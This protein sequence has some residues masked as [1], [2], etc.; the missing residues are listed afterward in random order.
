MRVLLLVTVIAFLAIP[1]GDAEACSCVARTAAEHAKAAKRVMLARAGKPTKTG[2]HLKQSFTVLATFKGP[3]TKQF[4]FDRPATPPCASDYAENEVAILFTSGGDLDPC[5]GNV[6]LAEQAP[7]LRAILDATGTKPVDAT[8]AAIEAALREALAK[9][10]HDRPQIWI[11]HAAFDGT[12]FQLGN[13]KLAFT[14]KPRKGEIRISSA[15]AANGVAFV[16]GKYDIEGL[17]F[18]VILHEGP[19]WT[20]LWSSVAET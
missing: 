19:T 13:S 12:S 10:T 17:R 14:K 8:A 9:Y 16:E 5:H 7:E 1:T 20:V 2:D 11:R 6:P 15:F 4:L 18:A 3:A